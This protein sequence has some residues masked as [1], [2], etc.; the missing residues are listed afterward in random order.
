MWA[1]CICEYRSVNHTQFFVSFFISSSIQTST[2]HTFEYDKT[3]HTRYTTTTR[4]SFFVQSFLL[5][6]LFVRLFRSVTAHLGFF[7][8]LYIFVLRWLL[9]FPI[10]VYRLTHTLAL[11]YSFIVL[12]I[13]SVSCVDRLPSTVKLNK[14]NKKKR[15]QQRRPSV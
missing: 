11:A 9:L 1:R 10:R 5:S 13:E 4:Y 12:T 14:K 8:L 2:V 7:H 3:P 6:F 15:Q